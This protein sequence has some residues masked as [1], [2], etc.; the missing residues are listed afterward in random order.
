LA[1]DP[2]KASAFAGNSFVFIHVIETRVCLF[3]VGGK[4]E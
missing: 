3:F 2:R 1:M 4:N